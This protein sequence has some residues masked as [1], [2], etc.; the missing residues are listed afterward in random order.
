M[1]LEPYIGIWQESVGL[2][3]MKGRMTMARKL[4]AVKM[5]I[6]NICET[7]ASHQTMKLR[8]ED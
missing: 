8:P 4:C 3:E 7:S 2:R 1:W 6:T 5:T